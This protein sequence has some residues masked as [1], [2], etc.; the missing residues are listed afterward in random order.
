MKRGK[1]KRVLVLI[2]A[3]GFGGFMEAVA[4]PAMRMLAIPAFL[5]PFIIVWLTGKSQ[6]GKNAFKNMLGFTLLAALSY[7]LPALVVAQFVGAEFVDLAGNTISL[8]LMVI[9]ARMRK[10]AA[11]PDYIVDFS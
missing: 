7:V 10:P 6:N 3:W 2:L 11:D 9:A 5:S 8:V 1:H 4:G